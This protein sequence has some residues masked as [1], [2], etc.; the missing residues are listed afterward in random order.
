M[1]R[2]WYSLVLSV[3]LLLTLVGCG[4]QESEPPA[5]PSGVSAATTTA[6]TTEKTTETTE[7]TLQT[8][9]STATEP[10]TTTTSTTTGLTTAATSSATRSATVKKTTAATT[11]KVTTATTKKTT[12]TTTTTTTVVTTTARPEVDVTI[13]E[14]YTFMQIARLLEQKGVC[15]AKAFYEVCQSYTPQSFSIPV[16]DDRCFRMEGYLFPDTYRFYVD[17]D[18]QDVLVRMLNNYRDKVGDLSDDTLI[19]ASIIERE[20]RS[21]KHM[22]LVSSVFHNRLDAPQE[23]PYLNA[24]P[25]RDY[26]NTYI[27]GNSLVKNQ[28]K[29]APLYNT[30]GKRVGLPAGPI[31]C[32][33]L[34]AI[35]AAKNPTKTNYYYFFYG[36]DYENHYSETLEEHEQKI[37]EIG[38]CLE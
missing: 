14:G 7:N 34:R 4:G 20:A 18:P 26:V 28:S 30:C 12:V 21:D 27:T 38:V 29:Y 9:T 32:P 8:S 2:K 11:K 19:L 5:Q 24:D 23:Y 37:A 10:V 22:K 25:T 36:N 16:S 1:K 17:D 6:A 13:P 31:C 35:E 15:T 3:C 33:G